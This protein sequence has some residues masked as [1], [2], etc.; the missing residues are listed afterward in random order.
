MFQQPGTPVRASRT[1]SSS[2]FPLS[3]ITPSTV[4]SAPKVASP[5]VVR[6]PLSSFNNIAFTPPKSVPRSISTS[7]PSRS[8]LHKSLATD[9]WRKP[10]PGRIVEPQPQNPSQ[11]GARP[12]TRV[13]IPSN[14]AS[15][16]IPERLL[17]S[18]DIGTRKH[19]DERKLARQSENPR[20]RRGA[21]EDDVEV[22]VFLPALRGHD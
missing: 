12:R 7:K 9:S 6:T 14:R 13:L 8:A 10:S 18:V 11:Q 21:L 1:K 3:P 20:L 15:Y 4:P 16:V 17:P 2:I 19:V 5:S 22:F